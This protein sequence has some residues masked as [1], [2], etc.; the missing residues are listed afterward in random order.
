MPLTAA[1]EHRVQPFADPSLA[2]SMRMVALRH[3]TRHPKIYL[4]ARCPHGGQH[5]A[6]QGI[7]IDELVLKCRQDVQT[8]QD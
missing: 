1:L 5:P 8:D 6:N 3:D 2:M 7:V 4:P